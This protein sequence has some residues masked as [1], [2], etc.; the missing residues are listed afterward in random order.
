[1]SLPRLVHNSPDLTRL[2]NEGYALRIHGGHLLVEDV[3]YVTSERTIGHGT[4]VCPLDTQGESTTRPSTHMMWFGGGVPCTKDGTEV[5]LLLHERRQQELAPGIVVDCSFSQKADGRDYDNFYDKVIAYAGLIVGHAQAI[6]P[7]AVPMTF[8]PV[9]TD[10]SE[11]VFKYLD[12]ASSRAGIASH[13][14]KLAVG[15]VAIIGLGGTG[16][17]ILDFLAKTPIGQI[18][19]YD[20]DRFCTHNAFRAP[21]AASLGE[22]NDAPFKVQHHA[23]RYEPMRWGIHPHSVHVTAENVQDLL[24]MDF[25]FLAMDAGR[26]KKVIIDRLTD[27]DVPFID[28][29]IGVQN[30]QT[31]LSGQVR[32]TT[33]LPGHRDHIDGLVSYALGDADGY[34]TNIQVVELNVL[35]AA[36]A[37][38]AFKKQLRFYRDEVGELHSLYRIDSN[39]ILNEFGDTE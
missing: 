15:R 32:V 27:S 30:D 2:V 39:E 34:E 3:P 18:H 13:S 8:K 5:P 38:I 24:S 16:A 25:V 19:L 6:D 29:G 37:V 1:M 17:Y 12:T 22:L 10:E 28:T 7:N 31:G 14:Q 9:R 21:A 4:L 11:S 23:D 33:S 26:D 36:H 35:A 20:G